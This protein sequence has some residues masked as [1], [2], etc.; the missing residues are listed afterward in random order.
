MRCIPGFVLSLMLA[1]TLTASDV[2]VSIDLGA[3]PAPDGTVTL[4]LLPTG[5]WAL[6]ATDGTHFP[7]ARGG[8][9]VG[10]AL[11]PGLTGTQTFTLAA[12]AAVPALITVENNTDETQRLTIAGKEIATWQGGR[13]VLEPGYDEKLRRGGYLARLLTPSGR[14]VTGNMPEKHKHHHGV[15]FSWTKTLFDDRHPDFWN[16]GK[17]KSG[18]QNES[19]SPVWS[20]GAWAGFT[21]INRYDDLTSGK[22]IAVLGERLSVVIRAPLLNDSVLVVDITVVQRC[23]TPMPLVLPTYHYGGLGLRGREEWDG[24][25]N[26]RFLSSEGK[27]RANGNATRGRWC[28]MGG[29]VDGA[30]AGTVILGHPGNVR[31]PQPLRMH[32]TEPF[33]CFAPSQLGDWRIA[34]D[35]PL[36]QR[37]RII[38]A[39]GEPD[40]TAINRR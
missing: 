2:P 24:V 8:D 6:K 14:L 21:A 27:T 3:A 34:P 20:A 26:T 30:L 18:V 17:S 28:W 37:Y 19:T 10:R 22:A 32:P 12:A 15:W 1:T 23:L 7:I 5:D 38:V 31:A 40:A 4:P 29:Q 16:M 9:G 25:A 35:E 33:L 13:G 39:D 36:V 11:V